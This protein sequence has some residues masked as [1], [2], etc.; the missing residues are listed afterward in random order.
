VKNRELIPA[1]CLLL[2]TFFF[3]PSARAQTDSTAV[4][5][6]FI[7]DADTSAG[8][9]Y[10]TVIIR[11]H[12]SALPRVYITDLHGR[13]ELENQKPE[14]VHLQARHQSYTTADTTIVLQRGLRANIT[15]SLP[16]KP[17][18]L[19]EEIPLQELSASDLISRLIASPRF[20]YLHGNN[21]EIV[22]YTFDAYS[23]QQVIDRRTDRA[24]AGMEYTL[25]GYYHMPDSLA[26]HVT[27]LRNWGT[28][29]LSVS[30]GLTQNPS[31]GTLG[32]KDFDIVPHPLAADALKHYH[33][34][35]ISTVQVGDLRVSRINVSPRHGQKAGLL[36][37]IWVSCDDFSLVGY[38]LRL[39]FSA[40]MQLPNI[41]H[42]QV[43]QQNARYLN[44]YWLPM[45]QICTIQTRDWLARATTRCYQYDLNADLPSKIFDG[46][47][48]QILP[49]ATKRDSTFWTSHTASLDTAQ[50]HLQNALIQGNLPA[51]WQHLGLDR[52]GQ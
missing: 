47:E 15:L 40:L 48:I 46:S 43:Y 26:Q 45:H 41:Q 34:E 30:P 29:K 7:R 4:L 37:D 1:F 32:S 38:D 13:I 8:L 39:N 28:W 33:Y 10:A 5:T 18:Q 12:V 19:S 23:H 49:D 35:L 24:I 14:T 20:E 36:G 42:W 44:A 9:P 27:G 31:R 51:A 52:T 11:Q 25:K 17:I 6:A 3:Q 50:M 2:F 21:S 16:P 22:T